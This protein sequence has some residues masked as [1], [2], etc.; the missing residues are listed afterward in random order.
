[1]EA[2]RSGGRRGSRVAAAAA[3]ALGLAFPSLVVASC[4]KDS[5]HPPT[6]HAG[7]AEGPYPDSFVSCQE[8]AQQSDKVVT[9]VPGALSLDGGQTGC[10][11]PGLL[12]ALADTDAGVCDGGRD[13]GAPF[14]RCETTGWVGACTV[15]D[16]GAA[17]DASDASDA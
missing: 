7:S 15:L 13:G 9:Q 16:A 11:R 12:C 5:D 3:V 17:S 2:Y 8:L 4:K 1:M 10:P 14:A 6:Y